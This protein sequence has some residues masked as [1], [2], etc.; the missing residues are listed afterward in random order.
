MSSSPSPRNLP[1]TLGE[2]RKSDFSE[3]RLRDRRVKDE[4]RDNL[5]ATEGATLVGRNAPP[6]LR[7]QQLIIPTIER[8]YP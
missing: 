3:P 8:R 1:G 6:V 4:L 2:L 5:M 7:G